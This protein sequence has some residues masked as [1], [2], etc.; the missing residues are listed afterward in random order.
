MKSL[1]LTILIPVVALLAGV[2]LSVLGG[3]PEVAVPLAC[4]LCILFAVAWFGLL[5]FKT[6]RRLAKHDR[7]QCARLLLVDW[8][9]WLALVVSLAAGMG[10]IVEIAEKT[11]RARTR[12]VACSI[13]LKQIG[14]AM[15]A[16][17]SQYGCYPPAYLADAEG[18]PTA[19]WRVLL[20][21]FMDDP[22]ARE[23]FKKIHL[24]EPWDS[25]HNRAA[26]AKTK[27]E[28]LFHCPT[29]KYPE[30]ETNYVM[31]VS[32]GTISDGPHVMRLSD[33]KGMLSGTI[34]VV[35]VR[36]SGIHWAEPRDLDFATMSFRINDP[37][38]KCISS[39]HPF[40]HVLFADGKIASIYHPIAPEIIKAALT[41]SSGADRRDFD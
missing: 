27:V 7:G 17:N 2:V 37:N 33:I 18:R 10:L 9:C 26:L 38:G 31:V 4:L 15:V 19:S 5:V 23:L 32:Q 16:Y 35:E 29:S 24:D 40:P 13:Y 12:R 6:V 11:S 30:S 8:G 22:E 1:R 41:L 14:M 28:R 20:L 25:P 36:G 39:E 21:P 34:V 3:D